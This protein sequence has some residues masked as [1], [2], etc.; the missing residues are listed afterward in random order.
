[1]G[2]TSLGAELGRGEGVEEGGGVAVGERWATEAGVSAVERENSSAARRMLEVG[3]E[4]GGDDRG[5]AASELVSEMGTGE[6]AG[7]RGVVRWTGLTE[8]CALRRR[9]ADRWTGLRMGVV[10]GT[11]LRGLED[12]GVNPLV[13]GAIAEFWGIA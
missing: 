2:I 10:A 5:L 8:M 9:G 12:E 7:S 11:D 6:P 1:M 3:G 13:L 4:A